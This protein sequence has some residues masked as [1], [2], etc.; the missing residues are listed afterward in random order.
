MVAVTVLLAVQQAIAPVMWHSAAV[1]APILRP[2][3]T[4]TNG[5][6]VLAEV[7]PVSML[8]AVMLRKRNFGM[9]V[10]EVWVAQAILWATAVEMVVNLNMI[11]YPVAM[12]KQVVFM[13]AAVAVLRLHGSPITVAQVLTASSES[14]S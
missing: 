10:K 11:Y 9:V 6:A 13:V 12:V 3:I 2:T 1:V 8:L 5:V 14:P 7:L 4:W